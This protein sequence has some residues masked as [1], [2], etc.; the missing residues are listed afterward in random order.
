MIKFFQNELQTDTWIRALS[1]TDANAMF[2]ERPDH[3]WNGA[4]PA[5]PAQA[6][7]GLYKIGMVD[8]AFKWLKGLAR[9]ANQGPFGQA[10]FVENAI[11]PENGGGLKAPPDPPYMCDWSVSGNGSWV[12]IIIESIFGIQATLNKGISAKPQFGNFDTNAE[13]HNVP[14]QGKQYKITKKG[15]FS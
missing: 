6:V 9:S 5:W 7:S 8:L 2:S 12:N 13:L 10:H 14:F 15:I 11:Q 4:Y 3:Q 1:P